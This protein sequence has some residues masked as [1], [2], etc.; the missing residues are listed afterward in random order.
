MVSPSI[1]MLMKIVHHRVSM[2]TW[3]QSLGGIRKYTLG[4]EQPRETP[5][6]WMA[7]FKAAHPDW[8]SAVI[9]PVYMFEHSH[10]A[11]GVRDFGDRWDSGQVGWVYALPTQIRHAYN[12]TRIT[13]KIRTQV[14][15]VLKGEVE[16]YGRYING[17]CYGYTIEDAHGEELDACWG[18]I[19]WEYAKERAEEAASACA[20]VEAA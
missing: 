9:L 16:E 1:C 12:C 4:D 13:T 2:T 7:A 15:E 6:E 5:D 17:E 11:L 14:A 19:G 3:E 18:F 20:I 10:V 8:R